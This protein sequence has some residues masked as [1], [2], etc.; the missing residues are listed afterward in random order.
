MTIEFRTFCLFALL[1][2]LS[3]SCGATPPPIGYWSF[4]E[5]SANQALNEASDMHAGTVS[6]AQ[7]VEG[8]QGQ[9]LYFDGIDDR[10]TVPDH[11]GLRFTAN[12]SFTL[13]AWVKSDTPYSGW[14]GI[15]NKSREQAPWYGLWLSPS[16]NW[17]FGTSNFSGGAADTSWHHIALVQ[18]GSSQ[19]RDIYIDG[20]LTATDNATNGNGTGDL[21][22]GAASGVS[23]SFQG[24]L[25]EVQLYDVALSNEQ[26]LALVNL[27]NTDDSGDSEEP[28]VTFS[29]PEFTY[30]SGLY[31]TYVQ[32]ELTTTGTTYYT[33]DGSEPDT[34]SLLY[35]E[36][37]VID[38]QQF[39]GG[40]ATVK[41]R[42]YGDDNEMSDVVT[43]EYDLTAS[44]PQL[45]P[46]PYTAPWPFDFVKQDLRY[47]SFDN[48]IVLPAN[49]PSLVDGKF[50][51]ALS[52]DGVDDA[53]VLDPIPTWWLGYNYTI[54]LW[55]KADGDQQGWAGIVTQSREQAPWLGL[56]ISP[57]G[58]WVFGGD[59]LHG[60]QVT[61]GWHHIAL[62]N[63]ENTR[64]LYVDGTLQAES[65]PLPQTG[66]GQ[67][68]FGGA[69]GV[70]EY[71]KGLIDDVR[72]YKGGVTA[73]EVMQLAT[74]SPPLTRQAIDTSLTLEIPNDTDIFY[75]QAIDPW[76][77][78]FEL[79]NLADKKGYQ[80]PTTPMTWSDPG[81]PLDFSLTGES[82]ESCCDGSAY[83]LLKRVAQDQLTLITRD[84]FGQL[85]EPSRVTVYF[86]H[87]FPPVSE[88]RIGSWLFDQDPASRYSDVP[89]KVTD[90]VAGQHTGQVSAEP[91]SL[92]WRLNTH[93]GVEFD[94]A[95]TYIEIPDSSELRFSTNDSFSL[96][97]WFK[98]KQIENGWQGVVTKSR[99]LGN[100]WGLW[101][102]P[103]GELVFGAQQGHLTTSPALADEWQHV[104]VMQ[105][106]SA[107]K[108]YLYHN[109]ELAGSG[110]AK[111]G[112]GTGDL[113]IA[114]TK[115]VAEFF[116]G[117]IDDVQLYGRTLTNDE[118][119][120]LAERAP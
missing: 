68:I 114:G 108:R 72:I 6:G 115:G 79:L 81:I 24:A 111:D 120:R 70:S 86:D 8:K 46:N 74:V 110:S 85:S 29:D 10:V 88:G 98:P 80:Y 12:Q 34:G 117:A 73:D 56:W 91:Y 35:A 62:V 42:S 31:V 58:K 16:G 66:S 99:D 44:F 109:G 106:G 87:E 101:L 3:L 49:G 30:P 40:Q 51:K 100:W 107:G 93:S 5:L 102:S 82:L 50:G 65:E 119:Y 41:A 83:V 55:V 2:P 67:L 116:D 27:D 92:A 36:A 61:P 60:N 32:V 76:N 33:L 84:I 113:V 13:A 17:I 23:E 21:I 39:D 43:V 47:W 38:E 90:E 48:D 105:D 1:A 95:T 64:Q 53:L 71:F 37:F 11:P 69:G 63:T 19:T 75:D 97:V 52:F 15:V 118:I 77:G 18:Q 45:H 59:N 28:P 7:S 14:Q 104:V 57:D 96:S 26:I 22:F 4:D 78:G 54:S 103:N 25:D 94:G 89:G 20:V 9:A 112:S